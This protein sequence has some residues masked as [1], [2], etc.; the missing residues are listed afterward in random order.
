MVFSKKV[1][2]LH[3][4]SS[5]KIYFF[6]RKAPFYF[7]NN[8]GM[9]RQMNRFKGAHDQ[10]YEALK[11]V[12]STLK[13][14]GIKYDKFPRGKNVRYEEY[15]IIIT[16][17]GDGTFLEASRKVTHQIIIGVNSSPVYSVGKL[18]VA[19]I[20]NFKKIIE[21]VLKNKLKLQLL[22]RLRMEIDEKSDPIDALN[23]VLICHKNPAAMSR[24][25]LKIGH[26][27]EEQRNSGIWISTAC[28]SSGAI[29]SAGGQLMN[30]TEK[31]M[32]YKPRELYYGIK[33]NYQLTGGILSSRHKI[34]ITSLMREGKIFVDGTHLS[35]PFSFGSKLNVSLSP[36]PIKTINP[37][38]L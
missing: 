17:G 11:V 12:E 7:K 14:Y 4:K 24:Y 27:H 3:K 20:H 6:E 10:H 34:N 25:C 30:K 35:F 31:E 15:N 16:L 36:N 37:E 29:H 21:S 2:L 32:Q 19:G 33:N 38:Y 28:G 23:D 8:P 13:Q 18:C 26:V 5:Y 22:H 1:L 9:Q